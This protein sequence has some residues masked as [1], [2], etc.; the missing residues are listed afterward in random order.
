MA[1]K[2]SQ[3]T[4]YGF[5]CRRHDQR[6]SCDRVKSDLIGILCNLYQLREKAEK[7]LKTYRSG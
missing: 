4:S 5:S 3:V 1:K 2:T 6:Y 7:L